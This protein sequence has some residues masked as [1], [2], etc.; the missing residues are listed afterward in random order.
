MRLL[1]ERL[2]PAGLT[3]LSFLRYWGCEVWRRSSKSE[4]GSFTVAGDEIF[5]FVISLGKVTK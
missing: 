1:E 3:L 5:A 2:E 4:Q